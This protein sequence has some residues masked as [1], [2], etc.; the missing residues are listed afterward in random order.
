M[1]PLSVV[2]VLVGRCRHPDG[3]LARGGRPEDTTDYQKGNKTHIRS[4]PATGSVLADRRMPFHWGLLKL[5]QGLGEI[6]YA[7]D[8]TR[9]PTCFNRIGIV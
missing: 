6:H 3:D 4:L 5:Q 1:R 8:H 7:Q 2:K 9:E